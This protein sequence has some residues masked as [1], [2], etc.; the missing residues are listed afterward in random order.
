M[1]SESFTLATFMWIAVGYCNM[2]LLCVA[3]PILASFILD[4][5]V[6][7]VRGKD[8][9]PLLTAAIT[10]VGALIV[11]GSVWRMAVGTF[12]VP[13]TLEAGLLAAASYVLPVV[14]AIVVITIAGPQLPGLVRS[15]GAVVTSSTTSVRRKVSAAVGR[16][17][18]TAS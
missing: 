7:A 16:R 18:S 12:G 5:V 17:S 2:L 15:R 1:P 3:T 11:G 10:T 4:G 13:E 6:V 8:V 14:V 9:K